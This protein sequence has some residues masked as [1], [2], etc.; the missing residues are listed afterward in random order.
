[1]RRL[2]GPL[3]E[4]KRRV[5]Q[6]ADVPHLQP[7]LVDFSPT[8]AACAGSFHFLVILPKSMKHWIR[9]T[10]SDI[11]NVFN[12]RTM[13]LFVWN[14]EKCPNKCEKARLPRLHIAPF[15]HVQFIVLCHVGTLCHCL[16]TKT[17]EWKVVSSWEDLFRHVTL[18]LFLARTKCLNVCFN[19]DR[20]KSH[21]HCVGR[22]LVV[23][24][25]G[26]SLSSARD[27]VSGKGLA[28]AGVVNFKIR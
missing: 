15:W 18:L 23:M 14:G 28:T 4:S 3:L 21:S 6:R 12:L 25:E 24:L 17:F 2:S 1:M 13:D 10:I 27:T 11:K 9:I 20:Y 16:D 5:A 22:L 19:A 8:Q 26:K 7:Q